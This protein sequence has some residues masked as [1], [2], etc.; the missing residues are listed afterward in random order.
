MNPTV[1]IDWLKQ[2]FENVKVLDASLPKTA[3]GKVS[4]Y[5]GSYIPGAL[6]FD[7]KGDFSDTQSDFPNTI[8][9]PEQ[10]QERVQ[11]LRINN[12]DTLVIYDA[13]GIYSAPRAWWL[14]KVMGH[15]KVY[16]L[17]G[18]LPEWVKGGNEV[19][20]SLVALSERGNFKSSL[21]DSWVWRHEDVK[22]NIQFS[23]FQIIDAR[24]KARFE[25]TAPEPRKEL[26]SGCILGSTN[27]PYQDVLTNGKFK[28]QSELQRI[29]D[30]FEGELVF[31]C[32]SGLTACIIIMAQV[33][34]GGSSM[35][36]YDGSWTEWAIKEKLTI[37]EIG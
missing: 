7:L 15:Q 23:E 2:N 10:F 24:S 27:L 37:D 29:F 31:S 25:G 18:G 6:K 13:M 19:V 9:S 21:N 17:D 34:A 28:S 12:S 1:T 30:E 36:L 22:N 20:D 8:P 26:R 35:R 5:K 11:D 3:S 33:I 14:F 4:D 32:G 16:V